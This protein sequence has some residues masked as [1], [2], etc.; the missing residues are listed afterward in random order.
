MT[1]W[2]RLAAQWELKLLSV[3]FAVLLWIF[4]T[5]GDKLEAVFAV[6]LDL[7]ERPL[8]LEV[9]SLGV[10]VVVV[11]VEGPRSVV[12]GLRE[13]HLRAAVSLRDAQAGRFEARILP[14][15]VVAPRGVRVV[16]VTPSQI[17][18]TLARSAARS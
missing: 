11:R 3:A 4:V 5:S 7:T 13:E 16:E 2:S 6:P 1:L 12:S 15:N 8:G 14:G 17:R 18:A 10:E 9:T